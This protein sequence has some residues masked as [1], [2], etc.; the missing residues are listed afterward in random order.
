MLPVEPV[1]VPL[2]AVIN[3]ARPMATSHA[4]QAW[5]FD[6]AKRC[7]DAAPAARTYLLI[8]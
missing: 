2:G 3:A 7:N 8:N 6:A 1:S 4:D 5:A